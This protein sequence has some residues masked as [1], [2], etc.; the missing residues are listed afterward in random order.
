M[1]SEMTNEERLAT[2]ETQLAR[3]V[4]YGRADM[5]V[6]DV[7]WLLDRVRTL[8]C[9]S[10][11]NTLLGVRSMLAIQRRTAVCDKG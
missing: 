4:Q 3:F 5:S 8:G 2:I 6:A 11:L 7:R 1:N 9:E 10:A